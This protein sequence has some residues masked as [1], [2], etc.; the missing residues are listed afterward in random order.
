[1]AAYSHPLQAAVQVAHSHEDRAARALAESQQ[2][3]LE[4]QN[5]LQQ[6]LM[7][8]STYAGMFQTEGHDGISARRFQDYAVFL[9]NLDQGITQLQRQLERLQQ[10]LSHQRLAW[11][12]THAKTKALEEVIERGRKE[13]LRREDHREQQDSDERNLRRPVVRLGL[14]DVDDV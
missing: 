1:M 11:G 4:Q 10:D 5:R 13:Q 6:L 9:N 7:F 3:L 8:R 12:Q 14:A 2:R